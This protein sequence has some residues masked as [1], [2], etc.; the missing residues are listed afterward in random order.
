MQ[1]DTDHQAAP[2]DKAKRE[3]SQA[4]ERINAD[5]LAAGGL[6]PKWTQEEAI[7]YECARECITHLRAIHTG[8]LYHDNPTPERR[9][10]IEAENR[11]LAAELRGLR[12]HDHAEIAR[13]RRD[14]GQRIREHMAQ[15]KP[16]AED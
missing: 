8:E 6:H 16:T 2:G 7:A 13:I 12:V 1:D 9:A 11:H 5:I 4:V 15:A 10:E 3:F 14:Y